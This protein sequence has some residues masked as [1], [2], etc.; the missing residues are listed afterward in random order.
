M[1]DLTTG[2]LTPIQRAMFDELS[3]IKPSE[4]NSFLQGKLK[5]TEQELQRLKDAT[6]PNR[7]HQGPIFCKGEIL[8]IRGGRFKVIGIGPKHL[9]LESLPSYEQKENR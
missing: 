5:G 6:I 1:Q 4:I 2:E 8:E 9:H 3:A 7:E